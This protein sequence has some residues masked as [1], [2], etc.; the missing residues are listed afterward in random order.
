MQGA[1]TSLRLKS[2]AGAREDGGVSYL[3]R[4][5]PVLHLAMHLGV[6]GSRSGMG[7]LRLRE[8]ARRRE[9]SSLGGVEGVL[10]GGS[11]WA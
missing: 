9:H 1:R 8:E 4:V 3:H 7:T 11:V 5:Q 2:E 6:H 10:C